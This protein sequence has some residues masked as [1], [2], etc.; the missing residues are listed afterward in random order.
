[1]LLIDAILLD[2]GVVGRKMKG[3]NSLDFLSNN[4]GVQAVP[5]WDACVLEG[6]GW[7]YILSHDIL[8]SCWDLF[9]KEE[10]RIEMEQVPGL[11]FNE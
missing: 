8:N 9:D 5:I 7:S 2:D 10:G 6:I 4:A 1:M 11:V 3:D